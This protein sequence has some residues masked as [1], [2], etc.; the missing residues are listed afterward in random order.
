M[1]SWLP[2]DAVEDLF[3]HVIVRAVERLAAIF[4]ANHSYISSV[5][6]LFTVTGIPAG[7]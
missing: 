5:R 2:D 4:R 1:F 3:Q 7:A 6:V